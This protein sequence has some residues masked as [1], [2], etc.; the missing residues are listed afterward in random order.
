M[1]FP[2]LYL[3]KVTL[4][5]G[6]LLF[7]AT[8]PDLLNTIFFEQQPLLL[9]RVAQAQNYDEEKLERYA[10]AV[11][12]IEPLRQRAF[13]KIQNILN[14]QD[15]PSIACNRAESYQNLPS[16]AQSLIVDYCNRSKNIV[17]EQGLT[18]SEFNNIT[19]EVKSNPELK[20]Q[21]QAEMLERQ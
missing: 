3:I 4:A 15:V 10:E 12:A 6:T 17:Q 1:T 21:V 2:H 9:S 19:A 8:E 11:L 20:E 14:S 7:S 18:V 16:Q 5:T 13:R